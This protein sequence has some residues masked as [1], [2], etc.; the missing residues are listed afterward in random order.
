MKMSNFTPVFQ[1]TF[2]PPIQQI[3]H[4]RKYGSILIEQHDTYSKQ[5]FR[6]RL[7]IAGPNG[8]QNLSIPVE[9]PFGSKTKMKDILINDATD[10]QTNILR[11]IKTA[12]KNSPFYEYYIDDFIPFFENKYEKLVDLN[13]AVIKRLLELLEIETRI[14]LTQ[15]YERNYEIDFRDLVHP[16]P[17][18]RKE[19]TNFEL[20]K[21][22]QL[23]EEKY[24]FISNLSILDLIFNEGPLSYFYLKNSLI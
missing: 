24:G 20:K 1:S 12:Y 9:K 21:Y 17:Q 5:T 22:H 13:T 4:I 14:E 3:A 23:F 19:D 16:K 7:Q 18:F 6:N 2:F 8:L 10:W 11:S 15:D